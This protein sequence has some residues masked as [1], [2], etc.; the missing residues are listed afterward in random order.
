MDWSY[1]TS[2]TTTFQQRVFG[3]RSCLPTESALEVT[4][5]VHLLVLHNRRLNF[6]KFF[7]K[8]IIWFFKNTVCAVAT[9]LL[10]ISSFINLHISSITCIANF[11]HSKLYSPDFQNVLLLNFIVLQSLDLSVFTFFSLL[12]LRLLT[13]RY[14]FSFKLLS[15]IGGCPGCLISSSFCKL[16]DADSK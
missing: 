2:T 13:T 10:F 14:I 8:L 3:R 16:Q 7:K 11:L 12:C 5:L 4:F 15:P 6:L 1:W 9:L